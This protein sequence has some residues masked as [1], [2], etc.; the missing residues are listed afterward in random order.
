MN[1]HSYTW[2]AAW[3]DAGGRVVLGHA[4]AGS[5]RL[6]SLFLAPVVVCGGLGVTARML[7]G[8]GASTG[9][10]LVGLAIGLVAGVIAAGL[11]WMMGAG[12]ATKPPIVTVTP[13]ERQVRVR[14]G[15]NERVIERADVRG[16]WLVSRRVAPDW[17]PNSVVHCVQLVLEL[18]DEIVVLATNTNYSMRPIEVARVLAEAIGTRHAR[19]PVHIKGVLMWGRERPW[20]LEM[21]LCTVEELRDAL[22]KS[23][24]Y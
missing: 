1:Y 20:S 13:G 16:V 4:R 7:G 23:T 9:F 10:V 21:P 8:S 17:R 14:T 24:D 15:K 12:A 11:A 22:G 2:L 19:K 6:A 18:P 5:V 3:T